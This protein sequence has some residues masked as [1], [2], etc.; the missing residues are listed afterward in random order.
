MGVSSGTAMYA[1]I[2]GYRYNLHLSY[3]SNSPHTSTLNGDF[4]RPRGLRPFALAYERKISIYEPALAPRSH[5][6]A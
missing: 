3:P 1:N 4:R 6:Q 2:F 5:S